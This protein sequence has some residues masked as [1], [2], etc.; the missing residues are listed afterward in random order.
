M[1]LIQSGLKTAEC[2]QIIKKMVKSK[3]E[4]KM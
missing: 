3:S 2:G 4:S 1:E